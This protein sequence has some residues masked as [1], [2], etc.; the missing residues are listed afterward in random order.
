MSI[1]VSEDAQ[2]WMGLG[3]LVGDEVM[4]IFF[5]ERDGD[6]REGIEINHTYQSDIIE[7]MCDR[8]VEKVVNIDTGDIAYV[9]R[10]RIIVPEK[11]FDDRWYR[12]PCWTLAYLKSVKKVCD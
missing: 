1:Y 3:K 11:H 9:Y 5:D 7:K 10:L 4:D 8:G 6:W 12:N 2:H